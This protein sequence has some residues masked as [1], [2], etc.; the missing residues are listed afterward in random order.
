MRILRLAALLLLSTLNLPLSTSA[1]TVTG[2]LQ[3]IGLN[4]TITNIIF[5][6]LS[7]PFTPS[8]PIVIF[9]KPSTVTTVADGK[10]T[11]T[12]AQ[13][14]YRVTIG[15]NAKDS[16]VICVPTTNSTYAWTALIQSS[17]TYAYPSSPIYEEKI[18]K[19]ATNGYA[20]LGA[21]AL[22]PTAELAT[23]SASS[24][25][26][27]RGDQT[28]AVPAGGGTV[29]SIA[30]AVPSST[31]TVSGSPITT[32]GTLTLA[33]ATQATNTFLTGGNGGTTPTWR[34]L[35]ESDIPTL[36]SYTGK[37]ASYG[38]VLTN[39]QFYTGVT[40]HDLTASRAMV[41]D[42]N[43]RVSSSAVTATELGYVSGVTSALQ[44]QIN[45]KQNLSSVLTGLTN[46]GS[47]EGILAKQGDD[48]FAAWTLAAGSS[49]ITIVNGDGQSGA[50]TFDLGTVSVAH[51]SDEG[52]LVDW[53]LHATNKFVST[54]L[55]TT[56]GDLPVFNG[57]AWAREGILTDGWVLK[58]DSTRSNGMKWAAESGGISAVTNFIQLNPAS[59]KLPSSNPAR[60][61]NGE[62]NTRLL[63]DAS[64]D[65][66][67]TWQFCMPD[68][69]GSVF[70]IEIL[71]SM[72]SATANAVVWD[73]SVMAVTPGDSADIVTESFDTVNSVTSTVPGTAGY[74]KVETITL[75]NQ[76]SVAAGDFVK[77]KINR[78]ANNGSDTATGDAEIVAIKLRIK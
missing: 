30:L 8:S 4:N 6:P 62:T 1:A 54:N 56:K 65:Q 71:Y 13:G 17:L 22:V 26:F 48:G 35:I 36:T 25:V 75:T 64:T 66:S 18:N 53:A 73:V 57:T 59:A 29:T 34:T 31:F 47:S 23:G 9:S 49:K 52:Q 55:L 3:D 16:F 39:A 10:F 21:A 32:S 40:N 68:Y 77:I 37:V 61:D 58:T 63:F 14:C 67:A 19:S 15:A 72:A 41:T 38:G 69:G 60:I 78:D 7:T 70:N 45:A 51:L 42:A 50:P 74:L 28:W 43:K 2:T 11:N 24:T 44:T 12:L 20:S 33:L 76:D 46:L 27:L 5:T